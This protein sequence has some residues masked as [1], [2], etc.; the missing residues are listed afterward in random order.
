MGQ[1]II[2][3]EKKLAKDLLISER[4]VRELFKEFKYAPGEY[5]YV[6]SIKKYLKTIKVDGIEHVTLKTL[7]DILC[8]SEKTI[9]NLTKENILQ[10]SENGNYN[11]KTNIKNYFLE[12]NESNK[13]KVVQRETQELKLSIL[14][15]EYYPDHVVRGVLSDMLIKFKSQLLSTSRKIAIEVEQNEEP[16]IKKIVEK[17]VLKALEELEKYDPPS[18]KGGK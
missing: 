10:K 14:K 12:N 2:A 7:A 9:R 3:S 18:N 11:L 13:L 4:R 8:V 15:D 6:K 17:H 16:D 5:E 1:L